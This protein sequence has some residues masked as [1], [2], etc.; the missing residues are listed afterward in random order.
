MS[1]VI[2]ITGAS[3]GLGREAAI[4]L[5]EQGHTVYAGARRVDRLVEL[6]DHG[7]TAVEMDVTKAAD[8][9][10]AVSRIL[11]N[12]GRIDVLINNAGFGLYGPVEDIPIDEARYQFEVNLF[13][14][15]H[16]TQFVLPHM[17]AQGSG[18]IVNI[19]SMV[20]KVFTPMG[21]WYVATKHALEGW[22]DCLRL[23]AA[24]FGIQVVLIEPGAIHTEFGDVMVALMEKF[25][26]ASPYH[27]QIE[28]LSSLMA[29]PGAV[30]HRTHVTAAAKVYAKAATTRRPRR[31][32]VTGKLARPWMYTRKWF[33]DAVYE[34]TVCRGLL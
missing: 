34:F 21:A 24:P 29:D 10:R 19:S 20:G 32:Y 8:N 30:E 26:D 17:R 6:A 25:P 22:S 23:E 5:A 14:L 31:R 18:R 9:E 3:A 27:S 28:S 12:E 2:L 13:G 15:A 1:K 4:L 16:L 7:V 11:D 33:G